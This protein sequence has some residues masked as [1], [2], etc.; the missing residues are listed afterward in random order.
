MT[1]SQ[2]AGGRAYQAARSPTTAMSRGSA[3]DL[4]LVRCLNVL[5]PASGA[6]S[7]ASSDPRLVAVTGERAAWYDR[8]PG[9]WEHVMP[10]GVRTGEQQR[11]VAAG[12][13][14]RVAVPSGPG[15]TALLLKR[16]A[17]VA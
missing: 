8:P 14:V 11:L 1:C 6:L 10:Y 15:A 16:L 5:M 17:G 2:L 9:S 7:V 12:T 13:A 3:A 4:A